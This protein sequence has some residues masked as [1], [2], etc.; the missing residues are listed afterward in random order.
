MMPARGT[1]WPG[2]EFGRPGAPRRLRQ[3]GLRSGPGGPRPLGGFGEGAR[4]RARCNPRKMERG[5]LHASQKVTS[6]LEPQCSWLRGALAG[7][8]DLLGVRR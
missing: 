1:L 8:P 2:L 7:T 5:F 3:R 6:Q 4:G